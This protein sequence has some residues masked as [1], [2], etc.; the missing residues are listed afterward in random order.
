MVG[1]MVQYSR[2][3]IHIQQIH[4]HIQQTYIHI[5][6]IFIQPKNYIVNKSQTTLRT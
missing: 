1:E 3:C 2:T 4:I 6:E 5:Q